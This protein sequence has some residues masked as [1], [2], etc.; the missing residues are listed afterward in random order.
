MMDKRPLILLAN[1]DGIFSEG[2]AALEE[3]MQPLG[4]LYVVAPDRERNAASHKI[5]LRRPIYVNPEGENRFSTSGT[6]ADCVNIGIHRLLPARPDL[7]VSGINNGANLAGDIGYSGTVGAARE[8]RLL[9]VPSIAFSL[10]SRNPLFY[11]AA[12]RVARDL[13]Q[14]VLSNGLPPEV[15]LNV[16]FPDLVD[17]YPAKIRWT[18][19][20]HKFYGDFLEDGTDDEG[21]PCY[22]YG[23]DAIQYDEGDA[24]DTDWRA[25]E[26]GYVSVTP[27]RLNFTDE[28]SLHSLKA[29][30]DGDVHARQSGVVKTPEKD[31]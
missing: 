29:I 21:R 30:Y 20:G 26:L 3:H 2:L 28:H 8:A 19:M 24:E 18:R 15:F 1:D 13:A 10:N 4:D 17:G 12:A 27:L 14:W 22:R 16:N 9:G 31:A 5:T 7:V 23:R 6:P 11:G 25:V